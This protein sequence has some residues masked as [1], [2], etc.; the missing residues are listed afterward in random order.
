KPTVD[1][2]DPCDP[3]ENYKNMGLH[4]RVACQC[5]STCSCGLHV[6]IDLTCVAY[7]LDPKPTCP[8]RPTR[9]IRPNSCGLHGYTHTI[10]RWCLAHRHAFIDHMV[11]SCTLPWPFLALIETQFLAFREH[12][13][14]QFMQNHSRAFGTL[15][16]KYPTPFSNQFTSLTR[17]STYAK[18]N[19]PSIKNDPNPN[20]VVE[21][22]IDASPPS[23]K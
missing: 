6:Q 21:V 7:M 5:G 1:Q 9:L 4:A 15:K 18:I 8:C 10:T 17:L 22:K 20:Q 16:T 3:R 13:W 2:S 14:Y 11:V 19:L 23:P 12:T